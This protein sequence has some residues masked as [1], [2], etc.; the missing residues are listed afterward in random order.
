MKR[1]LLAL[2]LA[3]MTTASVWAVPAKRITKTIEQPDGS[4]I[5]VTLQGDE[6]FHSYVTSDNLAVWIN[7]EGYAVY[8]TT[9]GPTAVLA[10]NP[11]DRSAEEQ[12]AILANGKNMTFAALRAAAPKYQAHME[13]MRAEALARAEAAG[14]DVSPY[15]VSSTT[16]E[17]GIPRV[18]L[19]QGASQVPHKGVAKVP[20]LLVNF[21]NVSF[22]N[23][24]TANETFHNFFMGTDNLSC[25][26]Y[27]VD[28][29]NG[30][31]DPQFDVY[32]PFTV[33]NTRKY[34]G[35]SS[36]N[37]NDEKPQYLVRDAI[38][39]ADPT[40]DFSQY[41]NDGDGIVDV[42][43][44]LYAGV[45]QASSG[46]NEAVWP[47]QW[48]LTNGGLGKYTTGEG[49]KCDKFA[50]FNELNG[51]KQTQIDG[52]GT[53]CHEFSHCLGLPDFY[54]TT[55]NYGY[56]GM[57]VWSLMD[58][59]CYND[60]GYTPAGY[61]A[62]EKAFMGWITLLEGQPNTKYNLPVLNKE[63]E[64]NTDAVILINSKDKNEY[65]I[66]ESRDQQG[67]DE[68]LYDKGMLITHVTYSASAWSSNSVNDYSLQRMTVVPADNKWNTSTRNGDLWPKANAYEFTNTSVPACTT[69]TG[70][71]L[72]RDVTEITRDSSTGV[73]SFWVDRAPV[74][75]VEPPVINEEDY[76]P[77]PGEE[78]GSFTALW[79]ETE[80]EGSD[81]SYT[82]Q[83]WEKTDGV[84]EPSV[85]QDFTKDTPV[86]WNQ[87]GEIKKQRNY[88][89][90]GNTSGTTGVLTSPCAATADNGYVTVVA[91]AKR[92][93]TDT[94]AELKLSLVDASG[95]TVAYQSFNLSSSK[96]YCRALLKGE[97][98]KSY[99]VRMENVG[100]SR[101]MAYNVMGFDGDLTDFTNEEFQAAL[102]AA[103]SAAAEAPAR[104]EV[105]TSGTG[106]ITI[107]GIRETSYKVTGLTNPN[108]TYLYRVKAVPDDET[109]GLESFWS[110]TMEVTL[111]DPG[112]GIVTI[113]GD[114]LEVSNFTV[115]NG[116]I[117]ATPGARLYT[118]SGLE[119]PARA[120]GQFSVAPGAYILSTPGFRPAK[121]I[122]K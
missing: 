29:S 18:S 71:Y 56:M 108:G 88:V 73:V 25:H 82:L 58:Y 57:D 12:G 54:E 114:R 52:P 112:A 94:N 70:S 77:V 53:F 116:T 28:A 86:T 7:D 47:C 19:E 49:V 22:K 92:F 101:V 33:A 61:T 66:F 51:A 40:V 109:K 103:S 35:G 36:S 60:D 5:E 72:N 67:W 65:F 74:S 68:Y 121:V 115:E 32:G 48:S 89:Q 44:V 30:L 110:N 15:R 78:P 59:A 106:R 113:S 118:M 41:D 75:P 24:S 90:L 34:Y 120:A 16:G 69:N 79:G 9:D 87:N 20:I 62:Y 8:V 91:Y 27:F 84:T 4:T 64:Q 96:Q 21:S 6:W 99:S 43:I 46:L 104:V 3:A 55:Y 31:Y 10:H 17:D 95:A 39:L 26:K 102:D 50:V 80:I 45:G 13:E 76:E 2:A 111:S 14:Q 23:A 105:V 100:T 85:W 97:A 37:G 63:G 81:V 93:G 117:S 122:V 38:Q 83:V 107:S 11:A 1:K 42:V 98:G 119:I